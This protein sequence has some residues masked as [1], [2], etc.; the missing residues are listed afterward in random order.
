[1]KITI[2][3]GLIVLIVVI[4]VILLVLSIE[5][6]RASKRP[7]GYRTRSFLNSFGIPTTQRDVLT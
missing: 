2:N 7:N 1:M 5:L 4:G 3:G 6:Y